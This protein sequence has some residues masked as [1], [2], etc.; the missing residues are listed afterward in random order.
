V[1]D[2]RLRPDGD[3][4]AGNSKHGQIVCPVAYG[5]DALTLKDNIDRKSWA[6][7]FG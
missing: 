7:A 4:H 6:V 3:A 2:G 5:N 1:S